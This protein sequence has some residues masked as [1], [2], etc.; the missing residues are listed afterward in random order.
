MTDRGWLE[1]VSTI[2]AD[3]LDRRRTYYELTEPLARLAFQIKESRGEP[4][5]F[6]IDFLIN[7]FDADQFR[8]SDK[9]TYGQATLMEMGQDEVGGLVRQLTSLPDSRVP[10][11]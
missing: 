2:F 8:S 9:S 3:L 4:L 10:L 11:P 6:I 5:P 7:W 1:P